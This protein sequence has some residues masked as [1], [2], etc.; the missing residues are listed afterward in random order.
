MNEYLPEGPHQSTVDSHQLLRVY[1]IRFV[2]HDPYFRVIR[3]NRINRLM[4]FIGNIQ[5]VSVEQQN[6]SIHSLGKPR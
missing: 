6:D 4:E 5:F 2:Q 1:L 3:F